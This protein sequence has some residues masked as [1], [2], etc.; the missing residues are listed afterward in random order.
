MKHLLCSLYNLRLTRLAAAVRAAA[1]VK[2]SEVECSKSENSTIAKFIY[3][4]PLTEHV[5]TTPPTSI[6]SHSTLFTSSFLRTFVFSITF[7]Q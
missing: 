1:D 4:Y 7:V 6:V 5:A 3:P 2:I